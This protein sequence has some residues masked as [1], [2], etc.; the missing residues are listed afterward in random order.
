M[1]VTVNGV[2]VDPAGF[3]SA[4]AAAAHE[5][6]RQRA[7]ALDLARAGDDR[8]AV[9]QAIEKLLARE[10][11]VPEP[12]E[13]ECRR[14]YD[15]HPAEFTS[16]ELA[17]AR[18]ILFQVTPGTP[19]PALR[20]KAEGVPPRSSGPV[21]LRLAR[22][23]VLELPSRAARRQPRPARPRRRR[24]EFEQALFNGAYTGVYP[25]LVRTRFGLHVLAVDRR[26]PGRRLP[27]EVAHARIAE[28]MR[29]RT[30]QAALAQFVQ[31]LAGQAEIRGADLAAA[32]T[33]LV[34]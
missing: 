7:V 19:V 15:A 9:D 29:G 21:A 17:C 8:A 11:A 13:A 32:A 14:Y 6:L 30:Q 10:V 26:E 22:A 1:A 25:Q 23:R 20:A 5:L 16:G 4:A 18:H 3:P 34:Q 12:T 2:A 31:V 24:A 28:R 33:P 27:F